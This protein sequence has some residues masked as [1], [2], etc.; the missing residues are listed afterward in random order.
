MAQIILTL[1]KSRQLPCMPLPC[2]PECSALA[3]FLLQV[4]VYLAGNGLQSSGLRGSTSKT[5]LLTD[6]H[7]FGRPIDHG[8]QLTQG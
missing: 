3:Q 6:E 2:L 5:G 4:S 8:Y 1:G 7:L